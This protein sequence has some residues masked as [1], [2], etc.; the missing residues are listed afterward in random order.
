MPSS[1]LILIL[2]LL[3]LGPI[4][5]TACSKE[6]AT[7][8]SSNTAPAAAPQAPATMPAHAPA[9][10]APPGA[11]P[12]SAAPPGAAGMAADA[13]P[14]APVPTA[15]GKVVETMEAGGGTFLRLDTGAEKIWV[16]TNKTKVT[17]GDRLVVPLGMPMRNFH[18]DA[19]GRDFPVIYFAT[20]VSRDRKGPATVPAGGGTQIREQAMS[21]GLAPPAQDAVLGTPP[22]QAAPSTQAMPPTHPP[23]GAG[24][25]QVSEVIPPAP[26]GRSVADLW[27]ERA[28]LAGKTVVVRGKVVKFLSG[29]MGRNWLHLQDGTGDARSGTHDITVTT[30]A[31]AKVGDV[32]TVTGTLAVDKDFGAGYRY[33]AVVEGATISQ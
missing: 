24:A 6:P 2:P 19:L 13:S 16:A 26:G 33:G 22:R 3:L 31:A 5:G 29:I 10:P 7:T 8:A 12:S 20:S 27:A 9:S 21:A 28:A 23:V 17:V 11:T 32:L 4:A 30:T 25:V 18:S 15:T 14:A 1:R